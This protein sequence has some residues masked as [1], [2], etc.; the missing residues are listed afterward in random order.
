MMVSLVCARKYSDYSLY[1]RAGMVEC[2]SYLDCRAQDLGTMT[3]EEC[4]VINPRGLSFVRS[5]IG[6]GP[7][8]H[9]CS[10]MYD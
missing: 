10:G 6:E 7:R 3:A 1:I 2:S 4:C 8:C 9:M 5:R